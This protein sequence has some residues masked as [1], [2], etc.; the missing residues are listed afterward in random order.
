MQACSS[1]Q[2]VTFTGPCYAS[3]AMCS[4]SKPGS[5]SV[6]DW[7]LHVGD[8]GVWP[9]PARMD[10]ASRNHDGADDF[11]SWLTGGRLP[12]RSTVLINEALRG[13]MDK[14]SL[15]ELVGM[16]AK[17]GMRVDMRVERTARPPPVASGRSHRPARSR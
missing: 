16:L 12:H 5:E 9:D 11:A 4:C 1:V 14:S 17:V 2:P 15:D 10:K 3:T 13:R 6:S 8:F 7:V